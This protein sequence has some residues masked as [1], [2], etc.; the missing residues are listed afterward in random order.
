MLH[1]GAPLC[2]ISSWRNEVIVCDYLSR[3][4]V[5]LTSDVVLNVLSVCGC[6]SECHLC[7]IAPRLEAFFGSASP[8][9]L[10]VASF[11]IGGLFDEPLCVSRVASFFIKGLF[12]EHLCVSWGCLFFHWR[13]F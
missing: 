3:C 1:G 12:D 8:F 4:E 10:G 9:I 2:D 7:A 11:F 5:C 6:T 13:S